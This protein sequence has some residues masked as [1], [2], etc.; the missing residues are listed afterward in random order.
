MGYSK[1][2]GNANE[3][4]HYPS[5]HVVW[6]MGL[7]PYDLLDLWGRARSFKKRNALIDLLQIYDMV[8]E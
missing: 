1:E 2:N 4:G 5:D 3:Q 6:G 8:M 7:G